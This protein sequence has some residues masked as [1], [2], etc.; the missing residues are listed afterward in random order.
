MHLWM[1]FEREDKSVPVCLSC[2]FLYL[3]FD[4]GRALEGVLRISKGF[5]M[6]MSHYQ[7][8]SIAFILRRLDKRGI[9][10][11]NNAPVSHIAAIT[12]SNR[13]SIDVHLKADLG[14]FLENLQLSPNYCRMK[15]EGSL[16]TSKT[17]RD[18][19]GEPLLAHRQPAHICSANYRF[20]VFWI[21]DLSF[22]FS[23]P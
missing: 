7:V 21:A 15:I 18:Y 12:G 17:Q 22:L 16:L 20:N 6:V 13:L 1:L 2:H 5:L 14:I 11:S 9:A 19:V 3:D 10:K 8:Q 23:H 4:D